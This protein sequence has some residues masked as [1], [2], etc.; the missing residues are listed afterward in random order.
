MKT[1]ISNNTS[2]LFKLYGRGYF[3]YRPGGNFVNGLRAYCYLHNIDNIIVL[4]SRK[5]Y[6]A[7]LA[8][9]FTGIALHGRGRPSVYIVTREL[10]D[11][12][13]YFSDPDPEVNR[14]HS[15]WNSNPR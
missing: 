11:E 14:I 3:K 5:D 15:R 12:D 4:I 6:D 13:H 1:D 7:A 10:A 9:N 2:P 8:E